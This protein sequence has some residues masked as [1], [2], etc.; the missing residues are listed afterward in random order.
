MPNVSS[1]LLLAEAA[2]GYPVGTCVPF[3]KVD[4]LLVIG[5]TT[6]MKTGQ[7]E[8]DVAKYP[9]AFQS[10]NGGTPVVGSLF[11]YISKGKAVYVK[12]G[13]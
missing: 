6:W 3:D 5:S 12:I 8:D 4:D 7:V 13:G 9:D 11:Q 10:D 2:K 1:T